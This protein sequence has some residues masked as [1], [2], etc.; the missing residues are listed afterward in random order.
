MLVKGILI[1]FGPSIYNILL[2]EC[3][4]MY[5]LYSLKMDLVDSFINAFKWWLAISLATVLIAWFAQQLY[6]F[7]SK[8]GKGK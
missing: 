1:K 7:F 6:R 4:R 5:S 2:F 3:L 8:V